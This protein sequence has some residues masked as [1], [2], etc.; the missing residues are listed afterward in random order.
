LSGEIISVNVRNSK[1]GVETS[2]LS[3]SA[4]ARLPFFA[5]AANNICATDSR[6]DA[7]ADAAAA[8]GTLLRHGPAC[9]KDSAR[10][11][12]AIAR[13]L[14]RHHGAERNNV[15]AIRFAHFAEVPA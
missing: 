2:A 4:H 15:Q 5:R 11:A 9:A 8:H 10:A 14:H 3:P 7:A 1:Q 6:A 13:H 12:V